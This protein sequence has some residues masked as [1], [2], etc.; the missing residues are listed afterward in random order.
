MELLSVYLWYSQPC[1]V[2]YSRWQSGEV[3]ET[4]GGILWPHD[5]GVPTVLPGH[6]TS[7][8]LIQPPAPETAVIN[9]FIAWWGTLGGW[10]MLLLLCAF[11]VW[12]FFA[13]SLYNK[14]HPLFSTCKCLC[15][16]WQTSFASC[17]QSSWCLQRCRATSSFMKLLS[18]KRQTICQV[19]VLI[20]VISSFTIIIVN[21]SNFTH[22][23][24]RLQGNPMS[25]LALHSA[26]SHLMRRKTW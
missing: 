12:C 3:Q 4:S 15:C 10:D 17:V 8:H 20:I 25:C 22:D 2:F 7:I 19:S 6:H 1:F 5:R 24:T 16:R 9:I 18:K 23:E 14:C 11:S 21:T 26:F 13:G